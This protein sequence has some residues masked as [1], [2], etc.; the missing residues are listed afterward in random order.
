MG[1]CVCGSCR[2]L[3]GVTDENGAVEI[4]ECV[5][6]YPAEDCDTCET[7]E[8]ELACDHYI[9]DEEQG[10]LFVVQCANCGKELHQVCNN[11]ENGKV[12]CI[13]CYLLNFM[14]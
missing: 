1:E 5:Y 6:G 9:S 10:E 13:D 4:F 7:G 3:K 11:D 2:N 12:H 8:C 14:Q